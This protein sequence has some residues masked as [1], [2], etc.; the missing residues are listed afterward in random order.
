MNLDYEII[1]YSDIASIS[2]YY[3]CLVFLE[4]IFGLINKIVVN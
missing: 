4:K 2:R 1:Q 3:T